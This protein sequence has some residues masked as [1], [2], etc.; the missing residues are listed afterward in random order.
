M[1]SDDAPPARLP[2]L[3]KLV[4]GH[5]GVLLRK[6]VRQLNQSVDGAAVITLVDGKLAVSA[7][8]ERLILG[9]AEG[10]FCN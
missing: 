10:D 7:N 1:D 4:T 5:G 9:C 6:D 8:F 3:S 2:K